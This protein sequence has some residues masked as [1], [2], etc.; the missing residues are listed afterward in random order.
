ME[1]TWKQTTWYVFHK[2]S[3]EFIPE[4][5]EH[6]KNFYNSFKTI[7]PCEICLN[8]YNIQL[9]R[10][11]LTINENINKDKMFEWT[12]KLHNNVN[13]THKKKEW[14]IVE[15]R[16]YYDS[17]K[18]DPNYVKIMILDLVRNNFKKGPMKTNELLIMLNSM[19]FIYPDK[20][21]REKLINMNIKLDYSNIRDWLL[22]FLKIIYLN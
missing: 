16:N 11:G 8:H 22:E 21:I 13:A 17:N 2:F 15:A 20:N 3:L 9:N 19:R 1:L 14:S 7:L 4:S 6:Y 12:V 10:N 18:L 5:I